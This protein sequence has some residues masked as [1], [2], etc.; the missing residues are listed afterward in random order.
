MATIACQLRT[1]PSGVKNVVTHKTRKQQS[2]PADASPHS[3]DSAAAATSD[4]L[5][6][7]LRPSLASCC[8]L[9]GWRYG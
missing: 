6:G 5:P 2:P 4:R 7:A 3:T 8:A 1:C 9:R